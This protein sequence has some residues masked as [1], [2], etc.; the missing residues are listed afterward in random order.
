LVCDDRLLQDR[1]AHH[2]CSPGSRTPT[3]A[4]SNAFADSNANGH[5]NGYAYADSNANGDG[6]CYRNLNTCTNANCDSYTHP[7]TDAYSAAHP[8]TKDG[9]GTKASSNR[10][11]AP[12]GLLPARRA[13][14]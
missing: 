11:T 5:S 7:N 14:K 9:S 12:L 8:D 13:E 3:D 1:V 6:Y 4:D 10:A 2:C